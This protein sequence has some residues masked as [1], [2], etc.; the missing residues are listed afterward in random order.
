VRYG[1]LG[2]VT[3]QNLARA[4]TLD[5]ITAGNGADGIEYTD[6]TRGLEV[7]VTSSRN[8]NPITPANNCNGTT[9]HGESSIIRVDGTY[10]DNQGPNIADVL[11]ASSLNV[12]CRASGSIA[13]QLTQRVG[14]WSHGLVWLDGCD[15]TG[16]PEADLKTQDASGAIYHH[17][18]R[19]G[20]VTGAGVVRAGRGS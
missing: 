20:S 17:A 18:T 11:G 13:T 19:F 15:V 10:L 8:G 5:T 4:T 16:N 14:V 6:T 7:G 9:G 3:Y 12:R 1:R 2:G